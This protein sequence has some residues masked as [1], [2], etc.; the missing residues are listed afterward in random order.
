MKTFV[1]MSIVLNSQIVELLGHVIGVG[2]SQ[3]YGYNK[4]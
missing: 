2:N 3:F 1:H 4:T